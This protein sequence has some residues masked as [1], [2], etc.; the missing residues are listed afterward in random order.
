MDDV[1]DMLEARQL[2]AFLGVTI[3]TQIN[4]SDDPS[5]V[6]SRVWLA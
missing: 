6:S 2:S 1:T 4:E 5:T 3:A